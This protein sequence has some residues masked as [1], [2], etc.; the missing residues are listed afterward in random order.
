[1]DGDEVPTYSEAFP[2]LNIGVPGETTPTTWVNPKVQRLRSTVVT[3][4]SLT[5]SNNFFNE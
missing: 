5:I 3:Q 1:M 4:V 2:P